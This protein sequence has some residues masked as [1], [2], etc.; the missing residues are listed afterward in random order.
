M[1]FGSKLHLPASRKRREETGKGNQMTA[2]RLRTGGSSDI[3]G[4][5]SGTR[6][7]R[8]Q[9]ADGHRSPVVRQILALHATCCRQIPVTSSQTDTGTAACCRHRS[10]AVRQILA[11]HATCCRQTPVTSSQTD[12][13]TACSVLQTPVTSSQTGTGRVNY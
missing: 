12:T 8:F 2:L 3:R 10:P 9:T 4:L 11:L 6:Q 5:Q 1:S 7:D 13:G